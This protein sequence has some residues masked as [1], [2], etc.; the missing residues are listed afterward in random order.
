MITIIKKNLPTGHEEIL[1]LAHA[2]LMRLSE[3]E[4]ARNGI[5]LR[6]E[7]SGDLGQPSRMSMCMR[8]G[9]I[10]DVFHSRPAPLLR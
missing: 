5:F 1:C 8:E 9:Y 6:H 3:Y 2:W 7:N 10:R 4:L